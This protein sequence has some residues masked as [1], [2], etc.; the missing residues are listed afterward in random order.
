MEKG[1]VIAKVPVLAGWLAISPMPGRWGDYASD[2]ADIFAW[3]PDMVISLTSDAEMAG[4]PAAL[5]RDLARQG[6]AWRHM[7]ITDFGVPDGAF[8]RLWPM[9]ASEVQGWLGRGGRVLVHCKGGCGR[10]GMVAFRVMIEAGEAA[11]PAL[12]RLR[13]ARPCAVETEAQEA[14]AQRL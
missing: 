7:P 11:G 1:F 9:V 8:D 3:A 12:L 10:S 5:A 4:P 13:A 2:L 14:W 6:I